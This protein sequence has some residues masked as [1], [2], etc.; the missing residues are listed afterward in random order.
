MTFHHIGVACPNLEREVRALEAL[1]YAGESAH[2]ADPL[3]K[4]RGCFVTGAPSS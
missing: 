3:Q 4:V 1:G 2:F